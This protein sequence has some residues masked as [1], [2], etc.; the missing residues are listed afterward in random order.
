MKMLF[1]KKGQMSI[2]VL[3]ITGII[4]MMSIS[5]FSYYT[6]IMDTTTA[7]QII[8]IETLKQIDAMP[9]QYFI[10]VIKYSIGDPIVDFCIDIE[11]NTGTLYTEPTKTLY[12]EA[13]KK[14]IAENTAFEEATIGIT[15][16]PVGGCQ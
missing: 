6:R 4:I 15:L 5:V 16:N 1:G 11:P 3:L 10:K 12:A 2:E 9:E 13:L 14:A 8:E 7:M